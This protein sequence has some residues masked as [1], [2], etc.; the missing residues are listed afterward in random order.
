MYNDEVIK[1]KIKENVFIIKESHLHQHSDV[2]EHLREALSKVDVE[3][4][5]GFEA[6][7]LTI[8]MQRVVGKTACVEVSADDDVF[9][10]QRR[11]RK[12]MTA[13]V[14]DKEATSCNFISLVLAK[15][16]NNKIKILTA[17]IGMQAE[18]EPL[19]PS[20]KTEQEFELSKQFW[21]THALIAKSQRYYH[22]TVTKECPWD[23][24]ENR[25]QLELGNKNNVQAMIEKMRQPAESTAKNNLTN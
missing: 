10:A 1:I 4:L 12:T 2:N 5:E 3:K 22:N 9:Y 21:A 18:K 13:L 23:K 11:G 25:P 14:K 24:F 19:D 8:D 17:Y 6:H 20:I 15:N 16:P 7:K